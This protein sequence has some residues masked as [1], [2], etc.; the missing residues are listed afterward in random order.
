MVG[1]L[2]NPDILQ[3]VL[4]SHKLRASKSLG[5]NFLICEEVIDA[6][7]MALSNGPKNLTELGPGLGTLTQGLIASGYHVRGIEKDDDFIQILP[8]MMP[9]KMRDNLT[10]IHGDLLEVPWE[11]KEEWQLVGNIPYNISGMIIRLLTNIQSVPHCAVFLMQKE[12]ADRIAIHNNSMSLLGLSVGLWGTAKVLLQVPPDCFMPA[13]AVH[14]S[15]I[16]IRPHADMLPIEKREQIISSAKPFFQAKRKQIAHTLK[17][18]Y[19]KNLN[20]IEFIT[21]KLN[22]SPSARPENL[23]V[24]AWTSLCDIL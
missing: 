4:G 5:Q 10:V 8:S 16:E 3:S 20:E 9:P 6:V 14:S 22:I 11:W 18:A 1:P 17:S 7:L 24:Q 19:G 13:P 12:V 15:V 21:N 23:S 2:V